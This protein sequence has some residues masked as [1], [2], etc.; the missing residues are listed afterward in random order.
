MHHSITPWPRPGMQGL[1]SIDYTPEVLQLL[2]SFQA[3]SRQGR[4]TCNELIAYT[5]LMRYHSDNIVFHASRAPGPDLIIWLY[6]CIHGICARA[7]QYF[8]LGRRPQIHS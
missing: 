8:Q 4:L 3:K 2:Y 6:A 1:S 5:Q 7:D